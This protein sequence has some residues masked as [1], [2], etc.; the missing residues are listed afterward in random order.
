MYIVPTYCIITMLVTETRLC[1]G[2]KKS[3]GTP[4]LILVIHNINRCPGRFLASVTASTFLYSDPLKYLA[5]QTLSP[6][7]T[8]PGT[9]HF[10]IIV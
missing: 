8:V 4:I 5:N 9:T 1:Y 10:L 3:A 2:C 7:Y 6:V